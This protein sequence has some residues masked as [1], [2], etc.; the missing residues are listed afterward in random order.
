MAK[1]SNG[2]KGNNKRGCLYA[3][4]ILVML[5][6]VV[7][8]F[9]GK[10]SSKSEPL[11]T[12]ETTYVIENDV[13]SAESSPVTTNQETVIT[14]STEVN[15]DFEITMLNVGQGLSILIKANDNY[16]IYDGGGRDSSSY[17]VSYL[18]RHG[19]KKLSAMFVSHYDEDHIAGLVGV[20][21]TTEVSNVICPDREAN[22]EI[23]QSFINKLNQNGAKIIHPYRG[24]KFTLGKAE[25][26][27]LNP[28]DYMMYDENNSSIAVRILYDD[29]ACI[30]TGD[31]EHVAEWDMIDSGYELSA[32][33][34]V[35]GHHGSDSS[36]SDEFVKSVS[37]KYAYISCG[38]DNSYGHP[39]Q[40]TLDTLKQNNVEI[41]RSDLQ[42]EVTCY[43]KDG[44]NYSFSKE[45]CN[46]YNQQTVTEAYVIDIL[47]AP[48]Y[49]DSSIERA[50]PDSADTYVVNT[51][52]KKFHSPYCDSVNKMSEKN[53]MVTECNR[54]ELIEQ[55]YSPCGR[56][57]P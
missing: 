39:A 49:Y 41:F 23:Y 5:S 9:A 17:V 55:G 33:L 30:L 34:L 32:Q 54:E 36:S 7:S 35:V 48:D 20:L 37:P 22:T 2:E 4:I 53:K 38:I 18:K 42:G 29:F 19:I 10:S 12:E 50:I 6:F 27:V 14:P 24:D 44:N 57:K 13:T 46:D 8:V 45:P 52:T 15:S 26:I 43:V 56:C 21:N 40:R 31:C 51:N 47:G 28:V 11:T 1:R 16:M 25:I 3:F